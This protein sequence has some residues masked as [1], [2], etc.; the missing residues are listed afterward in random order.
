MFQAILGELPPASGSVTVNGAVSYAAQEPWLFTGWKYHIDFFIAILLFIN[1]I[2]FIKSILFVKHIFCFC[3]KHNSHRNC[4][5][6]YF[7]RSTI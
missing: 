2:L 1:A 6:E 7:I 4:T 5:I 3:V